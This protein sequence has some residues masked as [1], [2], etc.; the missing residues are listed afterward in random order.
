[1]KLKN[2]RN[3]ENYANYTPELEEH[4][5]AV[6]EVLV[7]MAKKS[8]TKKINLGFLKRKLDEEKALWEELIIRADTKVFLNNTSV[9]D[10]VA[11][12]WEFT[13]IYGIVLCII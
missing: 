3:Q 2:Y 4:I 12:F 6:E 1:M 9:F 11:S 10:R 7:T 13:W 5:T 8:M